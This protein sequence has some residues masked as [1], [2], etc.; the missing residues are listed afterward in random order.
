MSEMSIQAFAGEEASVNSYIIT[1]DSH[2]I[3]VDTLRNGAEAA[4]LADMVRSTGKAVQAIFITHGH[5]DHFIGMRTMKEAFPQAR[6]LV[7]RPEIKAD[8][9]GFAGWMESIGWLEGQPQM[10]PRSATN[11]DGFDYAGLIEIHSGQHISLTGGGEIEIE[12]HY[13]DVE[14]AHMSTLFV[15]S[16]DALLS[17][18]LVYNGVHIWAGQG[19]ERPHLANW[20]LAL[21][22]LKNRFSDKP[23]T[24]YPGHGRRTDIRVLDTL[25]VY[26]QDFLAAVDSETSNA[27]AKARMIRLYP[28]FLEPDFL[29]EYS[30]V[31][32]G[33]DTRGR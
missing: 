12:S 13:H 17:S 22:N 24:V 3:V 30:I 32:H 15:P 31:N 2:A 29:L 33:P 10:K 20:S 26:I 27:G 28:D 9:I 8:I 18:D 6:I 14:C 19:V 25:R 23:L 5:P 1:N 11:P 16:L 4:K 7:A 21:G